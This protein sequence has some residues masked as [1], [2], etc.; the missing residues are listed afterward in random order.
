MTWA[1]AIAAWWVLSVPIACLVMRLTCV[2]VQND[3]SVAGTV[4]TDWTFP[5]SA[6]LAR[7]SPSNQQAP[8]ISLDRERHRLMGRT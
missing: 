4:A 1:I 8:G 5:P 2:A 6:K 3:P 7:R